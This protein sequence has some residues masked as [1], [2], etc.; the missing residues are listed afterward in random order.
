MS[1]YNYCNEY[2][3]TYLNLGVAGEVEV[4]VCVDVEISYD[5]IIDEMGDNVWEYVSE[6][7]ADHVLNNYQDYLP[8]ILESACQ[9]GLDDLCEAL[10][11]QLET[12]NREEMLSRL[13]KLANE[14][15]LRINNV[16][17]LELVS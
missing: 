15:I 9:D 17:Q 8:E 6:Y 2:Y 12:D 4:E 13:I 16:E 1:Y 11:G 7:L 14:A 10:V 3:A 5:D